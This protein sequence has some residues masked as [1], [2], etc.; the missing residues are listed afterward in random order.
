MRSASLCLIALALGLLSVPS[1]ALKLRAGEAGDKAPLDLQ[2]GGAKRYMMPEVQ[3]L[4]DRKKSVTVVQ[5]GACDGDFD[6]NGDTNDPVQSII[7]RKNV[8]AIMVEPN[9]PVFK[10]LQENTKT[11]FAKDGDR[12]R[13]MN[14]AVCPDKT[15]TVPFY[16]VSPQFAEDFPKAPHWAKY[17]LSSMDRSLVKTHL[18]WLSSGKGAQ[19]YEKYIEAVPVQC[20]TPRD[21][22]KEGSVEPQAV[23]I[24]EVDAEGF[25]GKIVEA[26]FNIGP[27]FAPSIVVY[28]RPNLSKEEQAHMVEFLNKRGY[29]T[30]NVE[31]NVIATKKAVMV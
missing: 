27:T 2:K 15:G 23:D 28:E 18:S 7:R 21:L 12:V 30:Q 16:V 4:V 20:N 5:V 25:D 26:F 3:E 9:P 10:K 29:T 11:H 6:A 24:L 31:K 19:K 8:R 1:G 14:M 22:L 17:Q 13:P